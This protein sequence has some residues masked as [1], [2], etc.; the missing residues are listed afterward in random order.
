MR[1]DKGQGGP[2]HGTE[3]PASRLRFRFRDLSAAVEERHA[4]A[5][6]RWPERQSGP[7]EGITLPVVL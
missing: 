3:A 1:N 5:D 4:W 2:G 6:E 7:I